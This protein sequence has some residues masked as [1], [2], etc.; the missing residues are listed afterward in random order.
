MIEEIREVKLN[1]YTYKVSNLGR[2]FSKNGK[3]LKQN[4]N[5]DGY[6]VVSVKNNRCVGVHR[7]VAM[8]FVENDDI[9]NKTEVNHKDFNRKNNA[10]TN[11]EWLS[12]A[13]NVK[14]SHRNNRYR[15]FYGENNPNYGNRKLSKFY[16]ENRDIALEKQSRKGST[17]GRATKIELYKDGKFIKLFNY[18][19]ECCDYLAKNHNFNK[20]REVVRCGIRRSIAKNVPYKGFK[21]KK[22]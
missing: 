12:H 6:F 8:A 15:K 9:K 22:I 2:V 20:D 18:I 11:L 4:T 10:S 3:E 5:H 13:D 14:Y 7:F 1:G 16:K 17:N 19:G 21:F